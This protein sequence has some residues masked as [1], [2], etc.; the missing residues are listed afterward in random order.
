MRND[1]TIFPASQGTFYEKWFPKCKSNENSGDRPSEP[2]QSH[3][4]DE[5]NQPSF[6]PP[7]SNLP[8]TSPDD[9]Q[10]CPPNGDNDNDS[11]DD[12]SSQG[13]PPSS[14]HPLAGNTP[15]PAP[16][17]NLLPHDQYDGDDDPDAYDYP[18]NW[19]QLPAPNPNLF[20]YNLDD[21]LEW[22]R[23]NPGPR[24]CR[25]PTCP[26][27]I[28]TPAIRGGWCCQTGHKDIR[29]CNNLPPGNIPAPVPPQMPPQNP[30]DS[31]VEMDDAEALLSELVQEGGVDLQNYL[32]A[33]SLNPSA[34]IDDLDR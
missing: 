27:F 34:M 2:I 17:Q 25:A 3:P 4:G 14:E 16:N 15:A 19:G 22:R 7:D 28:P 1:N 8:F 30:P 26:G 31:D 13:H 23:L 12:D 11:N 33:H 6:D 24:I 29:T 18:S 9:D 5:P 20:S 21:I 32:L 10:N